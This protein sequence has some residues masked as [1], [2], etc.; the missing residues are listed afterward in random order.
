M[1]YEASIQGI[2]PGKIAPLLDK[3]SP[4]AGAE[5]SDGDKYERMSTEELMAGL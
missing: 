5:S 4:F 2:K 1:M 3:L